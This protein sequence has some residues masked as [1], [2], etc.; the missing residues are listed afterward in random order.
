MDKVKETTNAATG[1]EHADLARA[2]M[3]DPDLRPVL[4]RLSQ[5]K[6]KPSQAELQ[7]SSHFTK[8]VWAQFEMLHVNHGVLFI[9]PSSSKKAKPKVVLPKSL[10]KSAL[11]MFH[12][13][14]TGNHLGFDK[15][16]RKMKDRFWRP[17]LSTAVREYCRHCITCA[18]CKTSR[19]PKAPLEPMISG[20][21][22][23]RLHM[24]IV[25]PLPRSKKGN[26][27]ILTVQCS[28]T[29]WVEAYPLRNQRAITCAHAFVK[30]WVCRFGVPG[31]YTLRPRA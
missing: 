12:D 7:G 1:W 6:A 13:G 11:E 24:D 8:A 28:F 5:G 31:K 10:T 25:G 9:T 22:M 26:V 21:P 18:T 4:E 30:N 23:Q 20:Y 17:G 15:T 19:R 3:E 14:V 29:K 2:Q 16:L 27:C